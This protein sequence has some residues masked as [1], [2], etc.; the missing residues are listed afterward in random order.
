MPHTP[1]TIKNLAPEDRPRE[2][3]HDKGEEALTT[4]ELLAILIGSG[5]PKKSAVELMLDILRDCDHKLL[6]LSR[7]T[8][9][10]LMQYNGIGEAKAI[11]LKAAMELG[12][13]RASEEASRYL[14]QMTQAQ[15]IYRYM[16]PILR[17]LNH[18]E[19]WVLLLN[20]NARLIKRVRI[21]QGGISETSVDVRIIM[22]HAIL[23]EATSLVL[24][25][26]HPSGS[27]RPSK[28]DD[29]LTQHTNM[30]CRTLNIRFL[31]HL[32]I[33]DGDYYSYAEQGRIS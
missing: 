24:V 5:S 9:E 17:D 4:A 26:N 33:T 11:T 30:A 14:T 3:L 1:T 20:N 8:I 32:V 6:L 27:I 15:T 10:E 2:K 28:A 12:R 23:A 22:K 19:C 18:E 13:R 21:S 16:H 31:D 25:H 7:L 29:Q